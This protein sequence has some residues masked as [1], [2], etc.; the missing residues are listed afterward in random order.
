MAKLTKANTWVF[1]RRT[2]AH[3]WRWL[4][5]KQLWA[6]RDA[7]PP[8]YFQDLFRFLFRGR[9]NWEEGVSRSEQLEAYLDGRIG[10][11]AI[12]PTLRDNLDEFLRMI[13]QLRH[14]GMYQ[15]FGEDPAVIEALINRD[16]LS[17]YG[18]DGQANAVALFSWGFAQDVTGLL[19]V[20][21]DEIDVPEPVK[22]FLRLNVHLPWFDEPRLNKCGHHGVRTAM[23]FLTGWLRGGDAGASE[24][25]A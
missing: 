10:Q 22:T 25:L 23:S 14:D 16:T 21:V 4:E 19:R 2:K 20:L 11:E 1:E 17:S 3:A 24:A 13:P 9:R 5:L 6:G 18:I 7:A 15:S 8:D 12:R